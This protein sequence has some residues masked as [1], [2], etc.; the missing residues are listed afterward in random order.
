MSL[1]V[2]SRSILL[3]FSCKTVPQAWSDVRFGAPCRTRCLEG[4][5]HAR[6]VTSHWIE[7]VG[8][9]DPHSSTAR[10]AVLSSPDGVLR[11]HPAALQGDVE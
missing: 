1:A 4:P 7:K 8:Q 3:H 9:D 11:Y 5:K 6:S 10:T 2:C